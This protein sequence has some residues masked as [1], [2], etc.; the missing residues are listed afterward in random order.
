MAAAACGAACSRSRCSPGP[1]AMTTPGSVSW[2]SRAGSG[3]T[4]ARRRG[5]CVRSRTTASSSGPREP[6]VPPGTAHL[7]IRGARVGAPTAARGP[8]GA[9]AARASSGRAGA[10]RCARRDCGPHAAVAFASARGAGGGLGGPQRAGV[11]HRRRQS[12]AGR[13]RP[14]RAARSARRRGPNTVGGLEELTEC[15][16]EDAARGYSIAD[17]ELEPGFAAVAAPARRFDGRIAAA[18]N[19]SG[20]SFRFGPRLAEA[21]AHVVR[22]ADELSARLRADGV[23]KNATRVVGSADEQTPRAPRP[24]SRDLRRGLPLRLR[25]ARI[26]AGGA[27]VPEAVLKHPPPASRYSA[28]MSRH[29]FL[30]SD[31]TLKTVTRP[32]P[33]SSRSS[34]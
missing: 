12:V 11:L 16:R 26:P 27:F 8:V 33:A 32:T 31:A 25:A 3:S 28:D 30:G 2:T 7:R 22:A 14:G 18:V 17:G 1:T 10:P 20:P 5:R 34:R 19:V 13:S 21:G 29:A 4:R 23:A 6:R 9:R 15:V 24:G